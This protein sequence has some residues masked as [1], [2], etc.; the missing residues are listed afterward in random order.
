SLGMIC[1][2]IADRVEAPCLNRN[3][4]AA[5]NALSCANMALS[6]Y[7]HLIPLDEVI[8]T[9]KKVGDAIPNTLRCTGLGGLAITKTA[10]KIEA[11]LEK[12]QAESNKKFFKVC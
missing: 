11:T 1:D 6:N 8:E 4:M 3:V 7:N 9:M 2:M 12:N 10:K 5:T